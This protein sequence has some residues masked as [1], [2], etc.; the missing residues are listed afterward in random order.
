[1]R[2]VFVLLAIILIFVSIR[3]VNITLTGENIFFTG[4]P[5]GY[6]GL[7][8][9]VIAAP[10]LVL[11][12]PLNGTYFTNESIPLNYSVDSADSIWYSLDS[13]TN[14][15]INSTTY[16]NTS[17]GA[18]VIYIYA[19]N[20][21]GTSTKN[22][23]FSVNSNL[24]HII[25]NDWA[26]SQKG[27]STN[28]SI[29]T[30]EQIQ[31]L[32]NIT[33][34]NTNN[35]KILFNQNI[36]MTADSNFSDN[37]TNL[38]EGI[39]ISFNRIE[40]NATLIPNFNGPA[41]LW[42][43]GLSFSNPRVLIDGEPCPSILCKNESYSGGILKFNI[44]QFF[45]IY[46]A[47]ETPT[48]GGGVTTVVVG[49][50]GGGGGGIFSFLIP[51]KAT[52]FS[53]DVDQIKIITTPGQVITKKVIVTNNL[54]KQLTID[55]SKTDLEGFLDLK[56]SKLTLNPKESKE[57]SLDF[58]VNS[59]TIPDMYV[60]KLILTNSGDNSE[61]SEV[62]IILEVESGGVLLDVNAEV[63]KEYSSVPPGQDVLVKVSLF[64]LAEAD[65][66]KDVAMN[67]IIKSE[68]GEKIAEE[69]ETIA[70]ETQMGWIKRITIPEGTQYGK[71]IIYITATTADGKV[72]GASDTFN[73]VAPETAKIYILVIILSMIVLGIV[74][75]FSIIRGRTGG[76]TR[77]LDIRDIVGR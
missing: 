29:L 42:L 2:W 3:A 12:L 45:S 17:D 63:V 59:E 7:N 19:N 33:L 53:T 47:E 65:K 76:I 40:L 56:E 1:M 43:Y 37:Q 16:F 15:T 22:V 26:G 46:S 58:V 36:N 11:S 5:V 30:Y 62:L 61:Q 35:G 50:G 4:K 55:L 23:S 57:I 10:T 77:K 72:A 68:N 49:G 9:T 69:K 73:V 48:G 27:D 13:G 75:Y 54:N 51:K 28:F 38:N 41:T 14:R 6:L 74:I 70:I 8:L 44:T 25:Y 31:N 60:G 52:S 64:N 32:S 67:Y 24:F 21:V 18:H 20:S 71:Y 66:R 34:E 39:N